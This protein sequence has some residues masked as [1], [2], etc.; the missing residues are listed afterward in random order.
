MGGEGVPPIPSPELAA[1]KKF[2]TL[3]SLLLFLLRCDTFFFKFAFVACELSR[4]KRSY[5]PPPPPF[6]GSDKSNG[7]G[8]EANRE[9]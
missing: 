8:P 2:W 6:E 7:R 9:A 3:D 5:P 4:N 1:V